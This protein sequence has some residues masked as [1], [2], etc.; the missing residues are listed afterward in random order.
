M[1]KR[2][3]TVLEVPDV[4]NS[5][6]GIQSLDDLSSFLQPAPPESLISGGL[7]RA[8]WPK[9][10]RNDRREV[11]FS[12]DDH[13]VALELLSGQENYFVVSTLTLPNGERYAQTTVGY[14][15]RGEEEL[16]IRG[17][18]KFRWRQELVGPEAWSELQVAN[19]R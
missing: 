18:G 16:E 19:P 17:H 2:F 15:I 13:V 9:P 10:S 14:Q 8:G 6:L 4:W 3:Q 5:L 12:E 11:S 1:D 7:T